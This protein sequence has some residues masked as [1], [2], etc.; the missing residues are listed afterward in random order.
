M[1]FIIVPGLD[2]SDHNHWQSTWEAGWLPNATR[3][4]PASWTKPDRDDWS[5]AIDDAIA[6]DDEPAVLIAHSLGC[7]AVAHWLT[8]V[9]SPSVRGAFLVAPPDQLA[10]TFPVDLLPTFI[11]LRATPLPVPTLLIASDNDPY[12]T[13]D[14]AA[15]LAADWEVPLITTGNDGHLN[16]DSNL[17]LWPHGQEL[18]NSFLADLPVEDRI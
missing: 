16:S 9:G 17:G 12:C 3:I 1:R 10:P 4:A 18:F 11:R 13:V 2:G 7:L 8:T 6:L 15:R 5:A 14:A